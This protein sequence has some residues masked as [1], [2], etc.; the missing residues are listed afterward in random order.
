MIQA[1]ELRIGNWVSNGEVDYQI[2]AATI[3]HLTVR[4]NDAIVLPIPIT[5]EWLE[6]MGFERRISTHFI[7][8][9]IGTNEITH[10]WLFSIT[11]LNDPERIKAPNVPFYRNGRHTIYFIHQLQNLYF[12]L[13][14]EELILK[15]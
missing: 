12:A 11:W 4:P 9:H 5:P 10:D 7:E 13:T 15:P 14:G 1:S 8:Y 6:R 2:T 3:M